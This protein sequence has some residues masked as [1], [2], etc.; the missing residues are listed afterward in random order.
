MKIVLLSI[1]FWTPLTHAQ[2]FIQAP[3]LSKKD[4][5][6]ML[7]AR[8]GQRLSDWI[9]GQKEAKNVLQPIH[10]IGS[11]YLQNKIDSQQFKQKLQEIL[12]EKI[13]TSQVRLL[14]LDIYSK[15]IDT[16]K[17]LTEKNSLHQMRCH[18]LQ[19]EDHWS[20]GY[21][22]QKKNCHF[23][24]EKKSNQVF[25]QKF[26]ARV[27]VEGVELTDP[28]AFLTYQPQWKYHWHVLDEN[29]D[30]QY[31]KAT[32]DEMLSVSNSRKVLT[33]G[34]CQAPI[35]DWK[36]LNELSLPLQQTFV[37]YDRTCLRSLQEVP[38]EKQISWKKP[39]LIALGILAVGIGYNYFKDHEIVFEF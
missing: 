38:Q 27:F 22:I 19:L 33:D 20:D 7:E 21:L 10:Q 18:L 32:V 1:L 26:K 31:L 17:S 16:S 34:N 3:G 28:I 5:V 25:M 15:K 39:A 8:Q 23:R 37:A 35:Y 2:I 24:Y 29:G 30:A 12:N 36:A 6:E 14:L 4:F 11:D 13:L 9:L